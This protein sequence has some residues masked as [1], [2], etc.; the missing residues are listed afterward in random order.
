[1]LRR[2]TEG[3]SITLSITPGLNSNKLDTHLTYHLEKIPYVFGIAKLDD[4]SPF[5]GVAKL[6]AIRG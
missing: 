4:G 6:I 5:F 1:L 3:L 2:R